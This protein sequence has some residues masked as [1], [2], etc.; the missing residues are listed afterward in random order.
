MF[1]KHLSVPIWVKDI[2]LIIIFVKHENEVC[3]YFI[4]INALFQN[5]SN[6]DYLKRFSTK[7]WYTYCIHLNFAPMFN[8]YWLFITRWNYKIVIN[9]GCQRV[10]HKGQ[11]NYLKD[12][13]RPW[14]LKCKNDA[15]NTTFDIT[16]YFQPFLSL[17]KISNR[18]KLDTIA[19]IS[20]RAFRIKVT[21]LLIL[22]GLKV[23][24]FEVKGSKLENLMCAPL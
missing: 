12:T 4:L 22:H 15:Q 13:H 7:I 21:R 3:L 5:Q 23:T 17:L 6:I 16:K 14:V 10:T 1:S 24:P 19:N 9:W 20:K 8:N 2:N 11:E 18:V